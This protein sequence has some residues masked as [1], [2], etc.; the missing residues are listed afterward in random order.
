MCTKQQRIAEIARQRPTERLTALNHYLDV[1][2]L[3]EAYHRVRRDSAPG[4]DGQRVSDYG[5]YLGESLPALLHRAKH[6]SYVAPPVKRVHL[7]KEGT[8]E[9]R[10]IGMPTSEDKVLQRAVAMLLEPIYEEAFYDFSYGFRPGRS[11]HQALEAFWQQATGHGVRWV[12]ELDIRKYFDS[13]NRSNLM[14]LVGQWIGDGVV[15]RLL[16]KWLHAGVME[17]GRVN[18]PETGTPQGGVISPLLSNI[19]L[20]EVFDRWFAEVVRERMKGRVFAVRFADDLV[21]GF[22]HR[23]D[24]ERVYRVIFQRFEKYGLKL[25]PEMTR[26]VPFGRPEKGG[27]DGEPPHEPGTFDFLG[28]THYW[29]RSRRGYWVI[30]RKTAAKRLRRTLRAIGDWC[31][32]NRH[33]GMFD[34]FKVLV[35]KLDGH[36]AYYGITGNGP[37]LEQVRT[38]TQKVWRKWLARRSRESKAHTWEWM[39][40]MLKEMFVFPYARVVHS[41]FGAKA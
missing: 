24:A 3:T 8:N 30:R 22:T 31:R 16:S 33:R 9:T 14:V 11:P 20:H 36:Y 39:N 29:G 13:V 5:Q 10:P 41:I 40:R 17:E 18:Y 12:L 19:Y 6:G 35:R 26:L 21:M 34:Q 1:E 27:L 2:G 23:K 32:T 7:P 25:H 15:L 28:F 37:S 4:V 38:A